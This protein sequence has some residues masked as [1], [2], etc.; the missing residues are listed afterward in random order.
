MPTLKLGHR[1]YRPPAY[2]VKKHAASE[3]LPAATKLIPP[4]LSK[5]V[6]SG[7]ITTDAIRGV[8]NETSFERG[9][10]YYRQGRVRSVR[11]QGGVIKATV[12]GTESYT[13]TVTAGSGGLE[14]GC[15]C[16]YDWDGYCKHIVSVLLYARD[17]ARKLHKDEKKRRD[18]VTGA[19]DAATGDQIREFLAEEMEN[20]EDLLDR[21]AAACGIRR[22]GMRDYRAMAESMYGEYGGGRY[23]RVPYGDEIDFSKIMGL[24]R[25]HEGRKDYEEAIRAYRELSEVIAEN[26]DMVDDSDGYYGACFSDAIHGMV[27]CVNRPGAAKE[28]HITYM[29]EKFMLKEPDYFA[30]GYEDA[31]Y[32]TCTDAGDLAHWERLLDPHVPDAIPR[33]DR[34]WSEHFDAARLV[35]MKI[36][37]LER[38]GSRM[39]P[40]MLAKHYRA[41]DDV[42]ISY[43]AHLRKKDRRAALRVAEEGA[44]MFP[45]SKEIKNILHGLY[46]KTDPGYAMSLRRFF[47]RDG[48]WKHYDELKKSSDDWGREL[49]S[50]I[51]ELARGRNHYVLIGMFM[52]ERMT[53]RAVRLILQCD[54]LQILEEYHDK[55]CAL[56]PEECHA[57]YRKHIDRLAGS[58]RNRECYKHVKEHLRKMKAV[59]N[60]RKE[61]AEFVGHLRE[62]HARQP[63][64][65]DEIR[66]L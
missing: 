64:F 51:D 47:L 26:M 18:S 17:N 38:T 27:R 34:G 14:C 25:A 13:V 37:I 35:M 10:L 22:A 61:F 2:G 28:Q 49:K 41:Y 23:G 20:N 32:S 24:A 59:P 11:M 30:D 53:D 63:A 44:E 43:I 50:I 57:A 6:D 54:Q 45:Y 42:C 3:G 48:S 5:A 19:L 12:A 36:T 1:I 4:G 16:P 60:H 8:C 40:D 62:R 52:R 21:F 31:L 65:L 55:V 7:G 56:Y 46:E 33:S 29:F 66:R 9:S 39:L 15:T 58:A